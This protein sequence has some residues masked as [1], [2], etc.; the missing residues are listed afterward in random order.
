MEPVFVLVHSPS[1]GPATWRPVAERLSVAG[2]RARV[3]SLLAVG[4]GE[5]PYWPRAVDAVRADLA[6]AGVPPEQPLVLVA[7]SNA[8]LLLPLIRV[9]LAQPVTASVFVDAALPA[10]TGSTPV[11]PPELLRVL[12]GLSVDG[13]LPRWTDWWDEEDV[14]PLFP[15]ATTRQDITAEQQ[16]L[17][18][19]Y[20]E[21]RVPVPDGWDDHPC[22]YLLFDP[23]Y[24]D[25]A[26]EARRRGWR[27]AELPG[28]HLHQ[29]VDP[30]GTARL[31]VELAAG[32][33]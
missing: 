14:A 2:Y 4:V 25:T 30:G 20:Y 10:R 6:L 24:Q 33:E 11:A 26:D 3:P 12:R 1:V 16:L 19:A 13:M 22:A 8:G 28:K 15:D 21:R 32:P 7:H 5:P 23:V 27:I 9:G 29:V 18:L 17:P 31:L